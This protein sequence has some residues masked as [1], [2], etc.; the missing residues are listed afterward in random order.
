MGSYN[1]LYLV[2][3]PTCYKSIRPRCID[4]ILTNWKHSCTNISHFETGLSDFHK[5]LTVLKGGYLKRGS[6]IIEYRDYSKYN[7]LDFRQDINNTIDKLS[8]KMNF[9]SMNAAMVKVLDQHVLIKKKYIR[10]ND[11]KYM[12]KELRQAIMHR[13]KRKNKFKRNR[14]DDSWNKCMQQ[15]N[16]CNAKL[17]IKLHCYKYLDTHDF[18]D[19]RTFW[20]TIKLFSQIKY[21]FLNP[22]ISLRKMKL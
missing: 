15:R 2:K 20:I 11:G 21:K 4:F 10:A 12:T 7:T 16:K 8:S 17:R 14:T 22:S 1:L 19:N 13:S 18:A 6:R 3:D 5:I 9:D